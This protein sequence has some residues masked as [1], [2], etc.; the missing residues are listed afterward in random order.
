MLDTGGMP[1]LSVSERLSRLRAYDEAWYTAP[2]QFRPL[3]ATEDPDEYEDWWTTTGGTIPYTSRGTL[4]LFRPPSVSR[5]V[6]ERTWT[7]DFPEDFE[8]HPAWISVDFAQD[9]IVLSRM[10]RIQL[11]E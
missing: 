2:L 3:L 7:L 11:E 4:R 8:E 10:T 5:D 6:P 1:N 9:L